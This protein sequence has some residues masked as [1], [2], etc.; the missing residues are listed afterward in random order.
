MAAAAPARPGN[1]RSQPL[2]PATQRMAIDAAMATAI[3]TAKPNGGGSTTGC[4]PSPMPA[5]SN[6]RAVSMIT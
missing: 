4:Q 5:I 6:S 3:I 2:A 1:E